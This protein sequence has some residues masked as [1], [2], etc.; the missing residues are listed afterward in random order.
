[1]SIKISCHHTHNQNETDY[2]YS[3]AMYRAYLSQKFS[4]RSLTLL[5]LQQMPMTYYRVNEFSYLSHVS[6]NDQMTSLKRHV[7]NL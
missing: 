4:S 7:Q 3:V 1:M 6:V 5:V 2:R